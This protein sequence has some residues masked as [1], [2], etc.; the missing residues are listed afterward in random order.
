MGNKVR[1]IW[2][3]IE[4]FF[5][6]IK[7]VDDWVP[8]SLLARLNVPEMIVQAHFQK[9]E[10]GAA[11][12]D[13]LGGNNFWFDLNQAKK[14]FRELLGPLREQP[15]NAWEEW[16]R[17]V[18][19]GKAHSNVR[20]NAPPFPKRKNN[21]GKFTDLAELK[22]SPGQCY[23]LKLA[24]YDDDE[25]EWNN[26]SRK[27]F[28]QHKDFNRFFEKQ[29]LPGTAYQ[30]DESIP[31]L[32]TLLT[33]ID[34]SD[35]FEPELMNEF[36]ESGD[37][38]FHFKWINESGDDAFNGFIYWW[39][40]WPD[41]RKPSRPWIELFA[42][43][44]VEAAEYIR[45]WARQAYEAF[46]EW[47]PVIA[48]VAV[49]AFVISSGGTAL[50]GAAAIFLAIL[51]YQS[52]QQDESETPNGFLSVGLG[53]ANRPEDVKYCQVLLSAYCVEKG[54][55]MPEAD[56]IWEGKTRDLIQV[57]FDENFG[58]GSAIL[59]PGSLGLRKLQDFFLSRLLLGKGSLVFQSIEMPNF[60][61]QSMIPRLTF[62]QLRKLKKRVF[63]DVLESLKTRRDL[64]EPWG[65]SLEFMIELLKQAHVITGQQ[66]TE[67]TDINSARTQL[68]E[69]FN[70]RESKV[71]ELAKLVGSQFTRRRHWS[72]LADPTPII[73][74]RPSFDWDYKTII[75]HQSGGI[76]NTPQEIEA[77][78]RDEKGI[79]ERGYGWA[80]IGFHFIIDK[81]GKIFEGRHLGFMGAHIAKGKK[82][83][84]SKRIGV[85]FCGDYQSNWWESAAE[86][87][88]P[89][90]IGSFKVLAEKLKNEFGPQFPSA[91]FPEGTLNL[92]GHY[93]WAPSRI[94]DCPGQGI[95]KHIATWRSEWGFSD[96]DKFED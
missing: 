4:S 86:E 74:K 20:P 33:G 24:R 85:V 23:D 38:I 15:S 96:F 94:N 21:S 6:D 79:V 40:D 16:Q 57:F 92:H 17:F 9:V 60:I 69:Y 52:I 29:L 49:V 3:E 66:F 89:M 47:L 80:D 36:L 93:D 51:F 5:E 37:V 44:L 71:V 62:Q 70:S 91:D 87:L 59:A 42:L 64:Q 65:D 14:N 61:S 82:S 7:N 12:W 63:T 50:A 13:L 32:A 67:P 34:S 41:K 78:H 45:K 2:D 10:T 68:D 30:P 8:N 88:S 84:N 76:T 72:S 58:S 19:F 27:E 35:L 48:A 39:A 26:L 55:E 90:Q 18:E 1:D 46:L 56:G 77:L 73:L 11:S 25:D 53:M 83:L 43:A 28:A 81:E 22:S 95:A 31:L 75:V 54:L